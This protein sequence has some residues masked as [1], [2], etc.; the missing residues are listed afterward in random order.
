MT[1][2]DRW[3]T[4]LD[5]QGVDR[6]ILANNQ[7][8]HLMA[9]GHQLLS[10]RQVPGLEVAARETADGIVAS[11]RVARDVHL[12]HPL[13]LCFGVLPA[14]GRQH[15][16]MHLVLEDGAA[17]DI[18]AHCFFPNATRVEHLMDAAIEVGD[19]AHLSYAEGH[20]HGPY[21]GVT[22]VP[23][24]TVKVGKHGLYRSDFSL[25]TGRVG[26]LDIDYEV[27]ADEEAVV[28]LTARVFGHGT[29]AI[30][31]RERLV[32][33]GRAARGLIKTRVAIEHD[34]T[35]EIVGITE[36]NAAQARGHVDCMEIVKDRAVA[37]AQ[38]LVKVT[39]PQ[40]KVTH[41]AAIGSVDHQQM[42]TLM[43]HGLSPEQAVDLIVGGLLGKRETE[44]AGIVQF[45]SRR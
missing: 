31:I 17:V 13:H 12:A 14:E 25:T 20:Y 5:S 36:G 41:E 26:K 23:K 34:A 16:D 7:T 38:P 2:L 45:K 40:A 30:R 32:L 44:S 9:S 39:H 11:I 10:Q 42:E 1:E 15:I 37:S 33:A 27:E 21:G 22:V 24:A 3:L 19:G 6:A 29:D 43:A 35:A 4:V 8:A 28:E 18:V